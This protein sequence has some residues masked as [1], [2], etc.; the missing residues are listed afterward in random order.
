MNDDHPQ[1]T[2]QKDST[3]AIIKVIARNISRI[4][5]TKCKWYYTFW[6]KNLMWKTISCDSINFVMVLD[7][8][9]KDGK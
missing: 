7:L 1:V 6:F 2:P 3:R 8:T 4:N 5:S 9:L